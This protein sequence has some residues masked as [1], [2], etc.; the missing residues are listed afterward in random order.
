[1]SYGQ[2]KECDF[3]LSCCSIIGRYNQNCQ[4]QKHFQERS[5]GQPAL[6]AACF[7]FSGRKLRHRHSW[8][9]GDSWTLAKNQK[10]WQTHLENYRKLPVIWK[11]S[12]REVRLRDPSLGSLYLF[13][14]AY[15]KIV[16]S[17]DYLLI[18]LFCPLETTK[19][20]HV[21][22]RQEATAFWRSQSHH[23]SASRTFSKW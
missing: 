21:W 11:F 17:S 20:I 7:L 18:H 9:Q 1:M 6:G 14:R 12:L 4:K 23:K 22:Q 10:S 2:G 13:A 5:R 15:F 16:T 8:S 19:L 3:L